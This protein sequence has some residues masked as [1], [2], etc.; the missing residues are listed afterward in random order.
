[1]TSGY[2]KNTIL[3]PSVSLLLLF[4]NTRLRLHNL[5]VSLV[6]QESDGCRFRSGV[7]TLRSVF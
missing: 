3:I 1:M 7:L 6:L 5:L 2:H 4:N